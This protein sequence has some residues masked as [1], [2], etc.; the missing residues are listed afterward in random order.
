MAALERGARRTVDGHGDRHAARLIRHVGGKRKEI[1]CLA[2]ER[3]R[4]LPLAAAAHDPRVEVQHGVR[5]RIVRRIA[6]CDAA[7]R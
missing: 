6:C 5:L 2:H 4:L 7:H 1:V 3:R